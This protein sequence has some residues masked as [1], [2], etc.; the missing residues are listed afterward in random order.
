MLLPL[1]S[2]CLT[3][4]RRCVIF[5]L[6]DDYSWYAVAS[7]LGWGETSEAAITVFDKAVATHGCP[8]GC[9]PTTASRSTPR[10]VDT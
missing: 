4:G 6:I 2:D 9:C 10:G 3:R 1:N 8:S 5:Q 7:H